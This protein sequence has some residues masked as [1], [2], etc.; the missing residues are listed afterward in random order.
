M[1]KLL[2]CIAG[3]FL[4]ISA[5]A[6]ENI[7]K[8]SSQGAFRFADL[9]FAPTVIT[10]P[11]WT[12]GNIHPAGA[13]SNG[14]AV[15]GSYKVSV[16]GKA[17]GT[18]VWNA[19]ASAN[20]L[21]S[22]WSFNINSPDI[23]HR[24]IDVE[25]PAD[26][27]KK[28]VVRQPQKKFETV[29]F[30]NAMWKQVKQARAVTISLNNGDQ[31]AI[32]VI[33][34]AFLT[35][36]YN[37]RWN[38]DAGFSVR[39]ELNSGNKLSLDLRTQKT[40]V[41]PISL[42]KVANRTF[43]DP[44][45]DDK[46]GGWTDQG[47]GNDMSV[48]D[49]TKVKYRN[50]LFKIPD[51]KKTKKNSIIVVA[52]AVR[53]MA[54]A[55]ITLPLPAGIKARGLSLLHASGWVETNLI[56]EVIVRY[57]DTGT[58]TIPINGAVDVGNWWVGGD[59][60][61]GKIVWRSQNPLRVVGLY[62]STFELGGSQPVSLTFR[63]ANP[64]A[65]WMLAGVTLTEHPVMM[66]K[67]VVK[68]FIS[69]ADKDWR[70]F[71]YTRKITPGSPMDFS[72]IASPK[73]DRPAGKYGYAKISKDGKIVFEKAPNKRLR[74]NGVN[75]CETAIYT[76]KSEMEKLAVYFAQQGINSVRFHHH[77]NS[78]VDPKSPNSTTI[79]MANLDKLEY[80]IAKLKEQ[81][82]Y[83]TFDIYTSRRLKAGDNLEVFKRYPGYLST[84]HT[85]AKNAFI[86]C[87]DAFENWK[88]FARNW[89]TH[90]NPYTG[91]T[92]A[93]DPAVV[94]VNLSNEDTIGN[95]WNYTPGGFAMRLMA[96]E[97]AKHLKKHPGLNP[98][99]S[100]GNP[101][102]VQ[103]IYGQAR[104]RSIQ[105]MDFLRKELGA[106]FYITSAN[107]GGNLASTWLRDVYD[108]V[109]DHIYQDHPMFPEGGWKAPLQFSQ[110]SI[111]Q[112]HCWVPLNILSGRIYGK[113]FYITEF[114]FCYPNMH[115]AEEGAVMGAYSALN[116]IDGIYRF[117]FSGSSWRSSLAGTRI[118]VFESCQD[119]VKQL[120][121]RIVAALFLRGDV[122]P[123]PVKVSHTVPRNVFSARADFG[124]PTLNTSGLINQ[125]GAVFDDR[126]V[127]GVSDHKNITD[128]KAVANYKRYKKDK[129]ADSVTGEIRLMPDKRTLEINTDRSAVVTLP[130]K[131]SAAAGSFKVTKTNVFQTLAAISLD[132]K[133]LSESD[134]IV[135]LQLTNILASGVRFADQDLRRQETYGEGPLLMRRGTAQVSL[136]VKGPV[137]VTAVDFQGDAL[138]KIPVTMQGNIATFTADNFKF[139]NG[140]AGYHITP[141]KK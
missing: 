75:L 26:L 119:V 90:K 118:A 36:Q 73:A 4:L 42:A 13:K 40:A 62:A 59:F 58:Q 127:D 64:E 8:I 60:R 35:I 72:H 80:F 128:A 77:D 87:D 43:A 70:T 104:K 84:G 41:F 11:G 24:Y 116:D 91:M 125:V 111:L 92:L 51:E 123:S 32:R 79:N 66:P 69:K 112:G 65:I 27:A 53:D 19:T 55:E 74:I 139:A 45:A 68:P 135:V 103:F 71:K 7:T 100:S 137:T 48:F 88:T 15:S 56:G 140:I 82:I 61:N 39:F 18:L 113:P 25:I 93:E 29:V 131:G 107:N 134:S 5:V 98:E 37:R 21:Q 14:D 114:D 126:P 94:F 133:K 67:H 6:A 99:A 54:P 22:S 57:A 10:K 31:V 101:H 109:D 85:G 16:S 124:Y 89:L 141:V 97:Y 3:A 136:A 28:M 132:G 96:D 49:A 105:M 95:S 83:I 50:I 38:K 122:T 121:D 129:I 9:K 47:P 108:V 30:S 2:F 12:L 78:L 63:I 117:N 20:R 17:A 115:R 1:K 34:D 81:G 106:R 86:F 130:A 76:S 33:G 52:G 23:L 120:S 102:F 110:S 44:K 46:Q 138:G